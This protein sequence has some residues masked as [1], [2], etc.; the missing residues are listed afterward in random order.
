MDLEFDWDE[1]KAR[2]NWQKHG[3]SFNTATMVFRDE[4]RIEIY[5]EKHSINED[6]YI[7]IGL[8]GEV[9]FVVY[10][11]CKDTIRLIS[12][13]LAIARERKLYYGYDEG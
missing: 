2:K 7:T 4:D 1:D 12:A 10:T 9:L 6:R 13:R 8:A 5:D 11:E 3:V